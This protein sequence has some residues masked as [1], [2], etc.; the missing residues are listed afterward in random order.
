MRLS[1]LLLMVVINLAWG[2]NF[3]AA[4]YA[5]DEIPPVFAAGL[6]FV[7]VFVLLL[8]FIRLVKGKMRHMIATA[9]VI[10]ALH[11]SILYYAI[12]I[13]DDISSVAI[14]TLTNVPF[15]TLLAVI[16]LG[17]RIGIFSIA[18]LVVAFS[19]VMILGFDPGALAHMEDLLLVM[20]AAFVYAVGA[21]MMR[22]LSG[23]DVFNLQAWIGLLG[24]VSV[25][26]LSYF[27]ESGQLAALEAATWK[28]K[29]A[30]V[31]S[32]V[33]SSIIGHGG[34]YYLLKRYPVTTITPLTLMSQVFA[35]IAS[36][37]LLGEVLTAKMW[38]GGLLTFIGVGVIVFRKKRKTVGAI[39][40]QPETRA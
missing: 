9:L 3:I 16:F 19:G 5:I 18:G 30:V 11:F 37:I 25:L 4:K 8:P 33:A 1:H 26:T 36:V 2:L 27:L 15:A 39:P 6:R 28:A 35:V 14:V 12:S 34:I 23:V 40:P 29:G 7:L 22:T 21:N 31:F 38:L 32:A 24:M 20:L 10:G 17:E 13:A